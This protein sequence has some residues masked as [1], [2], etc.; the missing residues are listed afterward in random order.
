MHFCSTQSLP[1]TYLAWPNHSLACNG[2]HRR[3]HAGHIVDAF[4]SIRDGFS[5]LPAGD[6]PTGHCVCT[7]PLSTTLGVH[8]FVYSQQDA[9]IE[10]EP[11]QK[12]L[13]SS[14]LLSKR[15][16]IHIFL[17]HAPLPLRRFH[18]LVLK[19]LVKYVGGAFL[20]SSA[21]GL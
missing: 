15:I 14:I 8:P 18:Q 17:A 13:Q 3:M 4:L 21:S 11:S 16:W 6:M 20:A 19:P 12:C 5:R 9:L 1:C 2:L 7:W 10:A